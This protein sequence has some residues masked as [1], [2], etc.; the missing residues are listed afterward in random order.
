MAGEAGE[1]GEAGGGGGDDDDSDDD[2]D[3]DEGKGTRLRERALRERRKKLMKRFED[4]SRKQLE[5]N[6]NKRLLCYTGDY[7]DKKLVK[8]IVQW[9]LQKDAGRF[10]ETLVFGDGIEL[11]DLKKIMGEAGEDDDDEDGGG[12]AVHASTP[13]R[14]RTSPPTRRT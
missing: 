7:S 14:W 9:E 1:A 10:K 13:T 12:G 4:K 8:R 6:C 11:A 5:A 3:D 2:G